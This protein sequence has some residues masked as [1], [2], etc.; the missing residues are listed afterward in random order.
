MP[1]PRTDIRPRVLEAARKRFLARGIDGASLRKIAEDA[2]TNIGM[3]YYY[4][5][6]KEALFEAVLEHAYGRVLAD[7]ERAL[8]PDAP[9]ATRLERMSARI[10]AMSDEEFDVI[11]IVLKEALVSTE[12]L[13][14][15]VRRFTRGH[16]PLVLETLR[17][18]S[19]TGELSKTLPLPV[20]ATTVVGVL[21]LPQ[22]IRRRLIHGV[23]SLGHAL[24]EPDVLA[25]AL[26]SILLDGVRGSKNPH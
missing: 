10:G 20:L 26:V 13:G 25:R 16:V 12:R 15:L 23:P 17:E 3:I 4:F 2:G 18:G 11:R 7:F 6:T 5:P 22:L 8:A 14:S 19:R 21:G 9:V 1:R 24:P